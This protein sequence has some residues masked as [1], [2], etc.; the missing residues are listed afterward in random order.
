VVCVV[1]LSPQSWGANQATIKNAVRQLKKNLHWYEIPASGAFS[2]RFFLTL[3]AV[4]WHFDVW[5][6]ALI[7]ARYFINRLVCT[8]EFKLY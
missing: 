8:V 7:E 1:V 6:T 3:F 2:T 5:L 4:Y